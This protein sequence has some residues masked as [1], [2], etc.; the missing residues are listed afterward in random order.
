MVTIWQFIFTFLLGL[1]AYYFYD[2]KVN[3]QKAKDQARVVNTIV[4]NDI[5]TFKKYFEQ[6]IKGRDE[7]FANESNLVYLRRMRQSGNV[8]G[9][10]NF[11]LMNNYFH[12]LV[13]YE[14]EEKVKEY[15]IRDL[16]I[17]R[18]MIDK[19]TVQLEDYECQNKIQNLNILNNKS[20]SISQTP[21]QFNIIHNMI[22]ESE[23]NCEKKILSEEEKTQYAK[24]VLESRDYFKNSEY[25]F[26]NKFLYLMLKN[27]LKIDCID[28]SGRT[29]LFIACYLGKTRYIQKLID[30]GASLTKKNKRFMYLCP[31]TALVLKQ[32]YS[33]LANLIQKNIIKLDF[34]INE[35]EIL[36]RQE[37]IRNEEYEAALKIVQ[38]FILRKQ[39]I[40]FLHQRNKIK[41]LKGMSEEKILH[42]VRKYILDDK[43]KEN[44]KDYPKRN[45][46]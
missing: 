25:S 4:S 12:F 38:P 23:L 9:R 11:A 36:K 30:Q 29:P 20:N 17:T 28:N 18:E 15:T 33:I 35:M 10:N 26:E 2:R 37:T 22:R 14:F 46:I 31:A 42:F 41:F 32:R 21:N 39:I 45:L 27:G 19:K 13:G 43:I 44:S 5:L 24:L 7:R 8:S 40:N 3:K 16:E 1:L 6:E 34:L